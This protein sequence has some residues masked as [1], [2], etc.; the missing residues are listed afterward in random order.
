MNHSIFK[1]CLQI[2]MIVSGLINFAVADVNHESP[3]EIDY[4]VFSCV[5]VQT[6]EKLFFLA[7]HGVHLL[8]IQTLFDLVKVE[9]RIV[10]DPKSPDNN[11]VQPQKFTVRYWLN[12][13]DETTNFEY[14]NPYFSSDFYISHVGHIDLESSNFG[15]T[16]TTE[17]AIF[18]LKCSFEP[19][20]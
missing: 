15:G 10:S 2:L 9:L 17:S 3:N 12:H 19:T 18:N 8:K 6:N 5:V 1:K 14:K 4:S 11:L 7:N 20:I 16:W 13:F